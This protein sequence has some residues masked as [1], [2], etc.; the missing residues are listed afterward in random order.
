MILELDKHLLPMLHQFRERLERELA[1]ATA[2]LA[3]DEAAWFRSYVRSRQLLDYSPAQKCWLDRAYAHQVHWAIRRIQST[4]PPLRILDAG[5]GLG[6]ESI[7]FAM[8]GA[9]VVGVDLWEENLRVARNRARY[10]EQIS[11]NRLSLQFLRT[12]LLR[13]RPTQRFD[14]VYAREA[15]SHIHPIDTFLQIAYEQLNPG[16]DLVICDSNAWHPYIQLVAWRARGSRKYTTIVDPETNE[17]VPYAVERVLSVQEIRHFLEEA[18]FEVVHWTGFG[19][20]PVRIVTSWT[21]PWLVRLAEWLER[22]PRTASLGTRYVI[23][24]RKVG[25][26]GR[27]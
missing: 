8:L 14:L 7:L 5:C 4:K 22:S 3:P 21:F 25:E 1:E 2:F 27:A 12:N 23:V 19:F 15:I 18:G 13:Y 26:N 16:G 6:T 20:F 17:P 10:W 9:W 24:G 11:G